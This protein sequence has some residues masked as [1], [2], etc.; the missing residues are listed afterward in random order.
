MYVFTD[1]TLKY[2]LK[3]IKSKIALKS[4]LD[5]KL[6]KVDGKGLSDN[7]FTD[8]AKSLLETK[9]NSVEASYSTG[10]THIKF[11]NENE[12]NTKT[13]DLKTDCDMFFYPAIGT[14]LLSDLSGNVTIPYAFISKS[15]SDIGKVTVNIKNLINNTSSENVFNVTDNGSELIL[16]GA[17]SGNANI[18]FTIEGN[19]DEIKT[20]VLGKYSTVIM[21][22]LAIYRS[23]DSS[24]V[25][26]NVSNPKTVVS[27][28]GNGEYE[29]MLYTATSTNYINFFNKT[30]LTNV[31]YMS[32]DISNMSWTYYGCTSL[33][34]T[35]VCGD[36]VTNM[37]SAYSLCSNL[38]GN[39][40]CR[41][42][43]TNMYMTYAYC[44]NL[45]GSPVCGPNVTDMANTYEKCFNLTGAPVCGSNVTSMASTYQECYKLTGSPVCGLNVTNMCST[46]Q[47]CYKL[48]GD[49]ACGPNVVDMSKA[50]Y[51]SYVPG[52]AAC[53][54]NVTNM[55][56]TYAQCVKLVGPAACGPNVNNMYQ[57][58]YNC[59]NLKGTPACGDNVF[60]MHQ[61]YAYC[62]NLT[63]RPV[64][65]N[66]VEIMTQAYY[67]CF[68]LTGAP[69][70]GKKVVAMGQAFANCY[71]LQGNMYLFSNFIDQANSV[72]N[73]RNTTNRL[74]IYYNAGA[75]KY[76]T[77]T[78]HYT[79][80]NAPLTGNTITWT[81]DRSV[82][83]CYYNAKENIYLYPMVNI[84]GTY[85]ENELL[86]AR[87][88]M[89]SGANV[90]PEV[91][92][93]TMTTIEDTTN[94]D[95]TITRSVYLDESQLGE[96]PS[97]ISFDGATNLLTVEKLKVD[98]ITDTSYMFN[99]CSNLTSVCSSD[100]D[101]G[102]ITKADYMFAGCSKLT[103]ESFTN[104]ELPNVESA[105]HIFDGCTNL[106]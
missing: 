6:D 56:R 82:N 43:V 14:E 98:N 103:K 106:L 68:N 89:N 47:E 19:T 60:D 99:G 55:S 25:P 71:N 51:Y 62:S 69:I 88:T 39:P 52:K 2:L 27:D 101:T 9:F 57:A 22:P 32:D 66:T 77:T 102:K 3:K 94:N 15:G 104:F 45:T 38:T 100:W 105:S 23:T 29:I 35:P 90:I 64:V 30:S 86:V 7:D 73:G 91:D 87:Y 54:D 49:A 96:L 93:A 8:S 40:V 81:D 18:S 70:C 85:R 44:S 80:R 12:S 16:E 76:H 26:S 92:S 79:L 58:Y 41:N 46:Y 10:M 17:S 59:I 83:G 24:L 48:T 36:K 67:N 4:E 1:S 53:G 13:I 74:N 97:S 50:Y 84:V 33:K 95:G 21:L 63:G 75:N 34:G 5:N 31:S 42:N 78:T 28:F 37:S 61:A 65:G 72:F 11:S 20:N